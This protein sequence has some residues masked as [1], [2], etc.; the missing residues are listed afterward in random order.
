MIMVILKTCEQVNFYSIF[1]PLH[2][3]ATFLTGPFEH[4]LFNKTNSPVFNK[5]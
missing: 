1:N 4:L 3:D 2:F 5:V